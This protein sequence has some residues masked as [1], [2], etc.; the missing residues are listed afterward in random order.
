[1]VVV[2]HCAAQVPGGVLPWPTGLAGGVLLTALLLIAVALWVRRPALVVVPVAIELA[3]LA[4][5][6]VSG[7]P[8]P[9]RLVAVAPAPESRPSQC[10]A[11][12]GPLPDPTCTP[13]A[14]NPNVTQDTIAATICRPG[15]TATV[16]PPTSYTND[17]K[18]HQIDQYG[19][20]DNALGDY[21]EDH[22]V[23]LSVG[24]STS[25]PR[26]LWPEPGASPN[27][28]DKVEV[29]LQGAVCAHQ[30]SLASAQQAIATDWTTAEQRLGIG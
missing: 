3:I 23:P 25:D 30:V 21:E 19:Y 26:N 4:A 15:W 22:L 29:D 1:M 7:V 12:R 18:R 17:L 10:Q 28:K 20:L 27:A 2:A 6:G 11:R 24:G 16:R 5:G 8:K 14:L 9:G 13:G